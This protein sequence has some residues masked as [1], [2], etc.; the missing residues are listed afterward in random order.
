[1]RFPLRHRLA[2]AASMALAAACS[3]DSGTVGF[4][5]PPT[6]VVTAAS[7]VAGDVVP[8]RLENRS[9][10]AWSYS[11]CGKAL[12]QRRDGDQWTTLPPPLVLCANELVELPPGDVVDEEKFVP[13]GTDPGTHRVLVIFELEGEEFDR[14]SNSFEV[15]APPEP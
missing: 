8:I 15:T 5:E 1:M 2:L 10:V 3:D 7:V 13:L 11:M 6:A 12:L 14:V 4:I 9:A